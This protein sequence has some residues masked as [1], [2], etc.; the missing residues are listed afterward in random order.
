MLALGVIFAITLT[1][2]P[3]FNQFIN[4][5][6]G[7]G[8]FSAF[9]AGLLFVS[10]FTVAT[11]GLILP[12]LTPTLSPLFLIIF[13]AIGAVFGDL[14]LFLLVKKNVSEN[15]APV[16]EKFAARHHLK[17]ILH[18]KYF[19]WTLPVIGALIIASPLPDELGISL[20]GLSEM[21]FAQFMLVS[22]LS[23]TIGMSLV[24]TGSRYL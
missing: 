17:K 12:S 9:F 5:L 23:H 2:I 22:L 19:A 11:G 24:V 3:E 7:F 4:Y 6:G 20:L 18:T 21:K 15:V 14:L 8:Y 13:A 16:Y 1:Q 10:T